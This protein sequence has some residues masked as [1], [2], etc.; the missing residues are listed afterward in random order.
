MLEEYDRVILTRADHVHACDHPDVDV[1]G[2][3]EGG[4]PVVWIPTGEDYDG[5]R[6]AT[7][8][9]FPH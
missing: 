6:Y 7:K 9:V 4:E 3:M 1:G 5:T 2:Q 8:T